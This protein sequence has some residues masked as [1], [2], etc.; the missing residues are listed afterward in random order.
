MKS[1]NKYR[2][3]FF[4]LL[5]S[6]MGNVKP[7]IVESTF[8]D[9]EKDVLE[10]QLGGLGFDKVADEEKNGMSQ[11]QYDMEVTGIETVS[12]GQSPKGKNPKLSVLIMSDSS[13]GS[14]DQKTIA[15][16]IFLN[17]EKITSKITGGNSNYVTMPWNDFKTD[18]YEL[19][20]DAIEFAKSDTEEKQKVDY[21]K[22]YFDKILSGIGFGKSEE[23]KS[24]FIFSKKL[25]DEKAF[26]FL[27]RKSNGLV[28]IT[29]AIMDIEA[30]K[31]DNLFGT[32]IP[33]IVGTINVEKEMPLT[34][35]PKNIIIPES[36]LD[37]RDDEIRDLAEK[38]IEIAEKY[39]GK[40]LLQ[41]DWEG[42]EKMR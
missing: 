3:R 13:D 6:E 7:L 24:G 35:E 37:K 17:D 18:G 32:K 15:I 1:I 39:K 33:S 29:P 9:D 19:I 16:T 34:S 14:D 41:K 22:S 40:F 28:V 20:K 10:T 11:L 5:E 26:L 31:D 30:K 4:S 38:G 25:K 8:S 2:N 42:E 36:E 23:T 21:N 27:I 12:S